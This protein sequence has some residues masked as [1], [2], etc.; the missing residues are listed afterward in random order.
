VYLFNTLYNHTHTDHSN[1][2]TDHTNTHTDHTNTN[3]DHTHTNTNIQR[4]DKPRI[5]TSKFE[6][7]EKGILVVTLT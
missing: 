6:T 7:Q 5:I 3:T 4:Y 2:H 1:T